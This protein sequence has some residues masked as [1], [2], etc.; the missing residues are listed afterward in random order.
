M[1][2]FN[3]KKLAEK[4]RQICIL[5]KEIRKLN[6]DISGLKAKIENEQS[7]K[8]KLKIEIKV[9]EAQLYGDCIP[10]DHCFACKNAII[11]KSKNRN[12][13]YPNLKIKSYTCKLS[14]K[15]KGFKEKE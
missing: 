5:E 4:E 15:C 6:I 13:N 10:G 2:L 3:K 8:E 11:T 9:L 1:N 12:P 7:E 14:L